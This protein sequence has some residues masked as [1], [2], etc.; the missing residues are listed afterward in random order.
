MATVALL[1]VLSILGV[2]TVGLVTTGGRDRQLSVQ[3]LD[4]V[5]AFYAAEGA[6]NMAMR[7]LMLGDDIDADGGAGS[8]SDDGDPQ[9][10]VVLGTAR[11]RVEIDDIGGNTVLTAIGRAGDAE[12]RI[13]AVLSHG[14]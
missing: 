14:G 4:T 8:V 7:E 5:R 6:M 12:R 1:I 11:L 3:R 2:M 13:E 9:T 10:D